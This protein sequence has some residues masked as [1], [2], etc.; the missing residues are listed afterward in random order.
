MTEPTN[1][2][3]DAQR[4]AQ[5][6]AKFREYRALA[7]DEHEDRIWSAVAEAFDMAGDGT[8]TI[9]ALERARDLNPDWGRHHMLLAKAYLRAHRPDDAI[10]E[11]QICDELESS[12]LD[13]SHFSE[14]IFY[15]LGYALFAGGRYKEAAE[16]W[17]AADDGVEFWRN[18]EPLK[19]FH[20]HRGWAHH[21][22]HDYLGAIEAYRRGMV[23]PGPGDCSED[24]EMNPDLVELAQGMNDR[25]ELYF[26]TARAAQPLDPTPP[27]ATPY[28]D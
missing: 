12:G 28:T 4:D 23:A 22:E 5:L 8:R 13:P 16:A 2:A 11:L 17:R 20:L 24:D 27:Q 1:E 18:A 15:Y 26:E 9:A 7:D 14:N 3:L 10:Q 19:D 21:L 25:I 6:V